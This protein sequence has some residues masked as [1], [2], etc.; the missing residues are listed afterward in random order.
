MAGGLALGDERR[1]RFPGRVRRSTGPLDRTMQ[2]GGMRG[3]G[4]ARRRAGLRRALERHPR[5]ALRPLTPHEPRRARR[6]YSGGSV[7]RLAGR[8]RRRLQTRRLGGAICERSALAV[9]REVADE[10]A[11]RAEQLTIAMA[12]ADELDTQR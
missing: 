2:R 7:A 12:G 4:A 9:A 3:S 10:P 1:R 8:L 11:R 6:A 5:P